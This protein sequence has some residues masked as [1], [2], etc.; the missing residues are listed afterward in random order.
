MRLRFTAQVIFFTLDFLECRACEQQ[1]KQLWPLRRNDVCYGSIKAHL[2]A[3]RAELRRQRSGSGSDSGPG[4][5]QVSCSNQK[6]VTS[7]WIQS[8]EKVLRV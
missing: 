6:T 4:R 8:L 3:A 1:I 7:G 5:R 2:A